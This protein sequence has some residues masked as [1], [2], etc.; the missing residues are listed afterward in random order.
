MFLF[1]LLWLLSIAVV[2]S[3]EAILGMYWY[4]FTKYNLNDI[5]TIKTVI[6]KSEAHNNIS[7][8]WFLI[9]FSLLNGFMTGWVVELRLKVLDKLNRKWQN[10]QPPFYRNTSGEFRS[11][12]PWLVVES[13]LFLVILTNIIF[14]TFFR[15]YSNSFIWIIFF[16]L[17][18]VLGQ[19]LEPIKSYKTTISMDRPEKPLSSTIQ[20]VYPLFPLEYSLLIGQLYCK[21]LVPFFFIL[22]AFLLPSFFLLIPYN[23]DSNK[24]FIILTILL[25]ILIHWFYYNKDKFYFSKITIYNILFT[26]LKNLLGILAIF[27]IL[28]STG[29]VYLTLVVS[30]AVGFILPWHPKKLR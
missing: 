14:I 3:F 13:P 30:L 22:L 15:N 29:N 17:G 25:G 9:V 20:K 11:L 23:D 7:F 6:E 24:A 12:L 1:L 8:Y 18:F 27:S 16:S 21:V 19:L 4:E 28:I 5:T 10:T 26:A 2:F